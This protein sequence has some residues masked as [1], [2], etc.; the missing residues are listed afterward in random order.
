VISIIVAMAKN[1]VIGA[2]G[3][4]P[5]H[6]PEELKRFKR[7]TLGH[8]LVMGRRTWESIGR[9]LPG[10]TSLVVTR[11]RGFRAPGAKVAHSLDEAIA[12]CGADD[13][14]FVIGGAELYAQALPRA[15]R[16]YL[17]TVEA[18]V[19]GDTRMPEYSIGDWREISAESFPADAR[20]RYS[21]RCAVYER[22]ETPPPP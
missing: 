22:R 10:R 13:E 12:A 8:H 6:L 17:T 14:I 9:P 5:W 2:N 16:L 7:L 4:I 20:H 15:A 21:F 1:R 18:D 3:A 11:Q 19:P